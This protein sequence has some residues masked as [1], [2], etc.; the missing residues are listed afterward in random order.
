[1]P[2]GTIREVT[3]RLMGDRRSAQAALDWVNVEADK[4][5][6]RRPTLKIQGDIKDA[7]AKIAELRGLTDTLTKSA[8]SLPIDFNNTA[9]LAKLAGIRTALMGLEKTGTAIAS[10]NII[11][12]RR[13][14]GYEAAVLRTQNSF[15]NLARSITGAGAAQEKFTIATSKGFGLWGAQIKLFG[16]ASHTMSLFSLAAHFAIDSIIAITGALIAL[17]AGA[18]GLSGSVIDLYRHMQGVTAASDGLNT[19]IKP[20]THSFADLQHSMQATGVQ[21]FG[22]ALLLVTRRSDALAIAAHQVA[23]IFVDW[24]AKINLWS[25]SQGGMN[26]LLQHGIGF[27]RQFGQIF[28]N[29]GMAFHNLMKVDPGVAHMLGNVIVGFTQVLALFTKLPAPI[30]KTAIAILSIYHYGGLAV[31]VLRKLADVTGLTKVANALGLINKEGKTFAGLNATKWTGILGLAIAL[32]YVVYRGT[33]ADQ[34]TKDFAAAIQNLVDN[35]T[36]AQALL[37]GISEATGKLRNEMANVPTLV[38]KQWNTLSFS[39]QRFGDRLNAL[40]GGQIQAV[41]DLLHGNLL[42]AIQDVAHGMTDGAAKSIQIQHDMGLLGDQV[43]KLIGQEGNLAREAG[44]LAIGQAASATTTSHLGGKLGMLSSTTHMTSVNTMSFAQALTVMQLAGVKASDSYSLMH[45]KV[46]MLLEGYKTMGVQQGI[47]RNATNA[48]TFGFEFQSSK[49]NQLIQ[50]YQQFLSVVTGSSNTFVT[51][52]QDVLSVGKAMAGSTTS[53][54]SVTTTFNTTGNAARHTG[55]SFAGLNA[56]SLQLRSTWNQALQGAG[57]MLTSLLSQSAAA[58]MGARGYHLLTQAGRDLVSQLL[59]GAKGSKQNTA[60]LY[61]LAQEAGYHGK[62][63]FKALTN[64]VGNTHDAMK[65]LDHI[66]TIFT[67]HSADLQKDVNNLAEA[68]NKNLNQQMSQAIFLASGGKDAFLAFAKSVLGAHGNIKD[69]IPSAQRMYEVI[70]QNTNNANDAH[71]EFLTFAGGLHLTRQKADELWNSLHKLGQQHERPTITTEASGAGHIKA[72]E[73]G[74]TA[75]EYSLTFRGAN[76]VFI[77]KGTT[78]TADD[79]LA[80]VSKGELVV[81]TKFVNAGLVDHLRGHIPGFATG[82]FAGAGSVPAASYRWESRVAANFVA[83][84][85]EQFAKAA[86]RQFKKDVMG[87]GEGV[88]RDAMRWIGKI[89]Y[90]WGGTRVPGGAD[91]SGFVQTIYGRHGIGAPRT[92]EEQGHWVRRGAPTPGGLAFYHSPAGGPDP[93]H[94]AIVG[95][96]G[97]VI[98]Q[99]GGM[100]PQLEALHFMPLLWTGTPPHGFGAAGR[101]LGAGS[102]R[103]LGQL[104]GLWVAGGGPGGNLAHIAA[105]I[106]L[107]ESGGNANAR[108]PSGASG[109]WQILGLPFRGNPFDPLTNARMAVYKYH[110]AN[111]FSPWVTYEDG[112]YRRFYGKGTQGA[113]PGWGWVGE[114]GPELV[115]FHGGEQVLDTIT[116]LTHGPSAGRGY[117]TGTEARSGQSLIREYRDA[118][119]VAGLWRDMHHY[120]RTIAKYY[121]GHTRRWMDDQVWHQTHSMVMIE[122]HLKDVRANAKK[123]IALNQSIYSGYSS[124]GALSSLTIGPTPGVGD[125]NAT[126]GNLSVQLS[127]KIATFKALVPALRKLHDEGLPASLLQQIAQMDP[128]TGLQYA[129]QLLAGGKSFIKKLAGQESQLSGLER[130]ASRGVAGASYFN[131][132]PTTSRGFWGMFQGQEKELERTFR[133]LG[134]VLG[135]EAAR[136]F[137]VPGKRHG[138]ASGGI[139]REPVLGFGLNSGDA[140]SFAENGS[141]AFIPTGAS[142]N[143]RPAAGGGDTYHIYVLD[144]NYS[145]ERALRQIQ[146]VRRYK[147]RHGNVS[148]G[149]G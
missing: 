39:I 63:S 20:L 25:K 136:W 78:P 51:F 35:M 141:E 89:P 117:A 97:R 53:A 49:V 143:S 83:Q 59:A 14:S 104:E 108:N 70:A 115:K 21:L 13:L 130:E 76:G 134:G 114:F 138:F 87:S 47:L 146:L 36:P 96:G 125:S 2:L 45:E 131:R 148:T 10:R 100:G 26:A 116:S 74:L 6:K 110:A 128:D 32:G 105:A 44:N 94:V 129:Q 88:V 127:A 64:W 29:L 144:D 102:H 71:R 111:G 118:T 123:A 137:H 92:S 28:G 52:A 101:N 69:M 17:G 93:G 68:I 112:A 86:A 142:M 72:V 95:N 18:Y 90:V 15:Q 22:G 4:V 56:S 42:G 139:L 126:P 60:Q 5:D 99:G 16:S 8:R 119:S 11:D 82:G 84:A 57:A 81:P 80:R 132:F 55:A 66:T 135:R 85:S 58:G 124:Y 147:Q 46:D 73:A 106:A 79:V 133:R 120:L 31:T 113:A 23:G 109:L 50:G 24:L 48:A 12:P 9:A 19:R 43:N 37:G 40:A 91:C 65:N 30:V 3:L 62:D 122:N 149:I 41:G 34:A 1:M 27:L 140:Y 75:K 7:S 33:Q 67:V 121:D 77:D 38:N 103:T 61:A 98:S 145:D 107:A 54:R